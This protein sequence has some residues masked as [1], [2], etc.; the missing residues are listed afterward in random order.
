M[1]TSSADSPKRRINLE[2]IIGSFSFL[3]HFY[4]VSI[5]Q[6]SATFDEFPRHLICYGPGL[7]RICYLA[8][9]IYIL[10]GEK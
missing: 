7:L 5:K 10:I 3:G 6:I 4:E 8:L 2:M 1:D 9:T